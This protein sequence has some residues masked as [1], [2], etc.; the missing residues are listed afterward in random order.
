[1]ATAPF[2]F[3]QHRRYPT[4]PHTCRHYTIHYILKQGTDLTSVRDL[5]DHASI[6]TTERYLLRKRNYSEHAGLKIYN[7]DFI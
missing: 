6:R 7:K 3:V 2:P 1:M 4:T 5:L